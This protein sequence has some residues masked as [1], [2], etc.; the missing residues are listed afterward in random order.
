[1]I[2]RPAK[3]AFYDY[4]LEENDRKREENKRKMKAAQTYIKRVITH[5]SF[6]NISFKEVISL[7][8]N[9]DQGECIIRPSSKV[10]K[11]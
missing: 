3:D 5:P 8:E 11:N 10:S 9:M 1:M 4:D 6:K 7:M 2:Y